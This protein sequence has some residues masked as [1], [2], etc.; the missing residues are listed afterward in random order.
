MDID[1]GNRSKK[2]ANTIVRRRAI[3]HC[4]IVEIIQ[5]MRKLIYIFISI[6]LVSGFGLEIGGT[7]WA[8]NDS[9]FV[10]KKGDNYL[11]H[12]KD[13][14][15]YVLQTASTFNPATC[16]WYSGP[17]Y[18]PTGYAHNY[19]FEDDE[20]NL[21][22]LAAP[23]QPE[24]T[25][26][27]SSSLPSV[28]MLRNTDQ[29]YYF[30]NW[31]PET[32]LSGVPEGGGIAKGHR[33]YVT[34][35][36][37]PSQGATSASWSSNQCWEVYWIEN[38]GNNWKMS[39][40]S[41][42]N[43]TANAARYRKVTVT[44][45]E[46]EIKA[47]GLTALSIPSAMNYGTNSTLSA[48]VGSPYSYI[49]AYTNYVFLENGSESVHN[50]WGNS[51]HLTAVP[52]QVNNVNIVSRSYEWTI[53]GE[54]ASY[55]S[56]NSGD[57]VNTSTAESPTLYYRVENTTG[58]KEATI[59]VT[60]TYTDA[61]YEQT[62]QTLSASVLVKNPCSNPAIAADPVI[63]YTDVTVS[64]IPTA[65][66]YEVSWK[67]TSEEGGW[68]TIGVE[69]VTSYSITGL[70]FGTQYSYKVKAECDNDDAAVNN[71]TT[72]QEPGLV[73]VGAIFGG[74]RMADVGGKTEIV[75]VNCD[76][77]NAIYGGNDIAGSVSHDDGSTIT[78]GVNTGDT[79]ESYGTTPNTA[80]IKIGSVYGGGNGYYAYNGSSFVAAS[81]NYKSESIEAG[82]SV[83]AMTQ[84][85]AV[86]DVV[87]TNEG[88]SSKVLNFPSIN[89]TAIRVS[90]NYVTVD[91]IFGGAKNAFLTTNNGDGSLI[92]I[93][94][95]TIY[96]VFGGNNF[97]GGQGYGL[98]H[99]VVNGTSTC[100]TTTNNLPDAGTS[101]HQFGSDFGIA[102]LFGGGNKVYG[103]TTNIEIKGGQIDNLFGGGNAADVYAANVT[104][105]CPLA[106]YSNNFTFGNTY[107]NAIPT[108]YQNGSISIKDDYLWNGKGI[109]NVR[110]LYGGNNMESMAGVPNVTLTSGS[111]GTVYGG[112]N[113]GDML[114]S[115]AG[116]IDEDNDNSTTDVSFN[117]STKVILN[118]ANII[119][120]Y[121]YGGCRMSNVDYSTWVQIQNGHVGTVFGGCNVSGDVGSTRVNPSASSGTADYQEVQGGTYVE[122]SGGTVYKN[123]Y[124][125]GNGFY[126]CSQL[127][128]YVNVN[129][130]SYTD[131]NYVGMLVPSHNQT[132]ANVRSDANIK[133]NVYAGGNLAPVGFQD[134]VA[135][136]YPSFPTNAVGWAVV[137]IYGGNIA[138]NVF[139]GG[140]MADVYGSNDVLVAGGRMAAVYGGNDRTGQVAEYSNRVLPD[141][142]PRA[143][144]GYTSL[145]QPEVHAYVRVVGNPTI[146]EVY[147]GGNGDYDYQNGDAIV[148]QYCN[149][150]ELGPIQSNTFVDININ[151]G[152]AGGHIGTVYGG[153]DGV[154]ASG[155]ITVFINIVEPDPSV[156]HDVNINTVFGGNNKGT[157][158]LVP[159]IILL[160]GYVGTVYG[161]CNQGA[162]TATGEDF[163]KEIGGYGNI[164]SYV[165]LL[166]SYDPDRDGPAPAV[167][168][169]IK[170]KDAIYGGCRMN[171]VT[172]NSL[173]LVEGGDHSSA[174]IYGGSDI[175]G[176]VG[177]WS[178]VAVTG[179][180]TGNIYGGGNGGYKY[181]NNNAYT[182]ADVLIAEGTSEHPITAPICANSGVDILGGQVGASGVDNGKEAF[183]GGYGAETSTTGNVT[184][185]VGPATAASWSGLPVIYGNIY[186]GSALGRVNTNNE[187]LTQVNFLNGTLHGNIFGGGLGEAGD[188]NKGKTCGKVEVNISNEEQT[189]ENCKIDLRDANIYGC[190]NTN[191][192]P[193][194]DVTVHIYKTAFN[195]IDDYPSGDNYTAASGADPYYA[196]NDVF[197]GGNL[198]GYLP[199][200]ASNKALVYV[201]DCVNTIKR[202]FGGGNAAEARHAAVTIEGG[203]MDQVFGGGNGEV[204]A[205]NIGDGGIEL[206]I[207]GGKIRQLFG[208]NNTSGNIS[209]PMSINVTNSGTCTEA[210]DEF[211]GGSNA[212]PMGSNLSP[213]TLN[214]TIGCDPQH[215][216]NIHTVYG[217]SCLAPIVGDVTL[218]IEGGT[219]TD[220][221]AG[222][223]GAAGTAATITGST[224]LNLYGGTVSENAFGG[225][226]VNGNITGKITVNVLDY[227]T[228][229]LNVHNVYGA[230]NATNY[231]PTPTDPPISSPEVNVIHVSQDAGISGNVYGGGRQGAVTADPV[232]NIGYYALTMSGLIPSNYPATSSLT[233][234]PRAFVT[235]NVFGGGEEAGVTGNP[236]INM[237]SGTVLGGLYGG[238]NINGIVTGNTT[239]LFTGGTMGAAAVG[240]EGQVGYVAQQN[241]NIYGGGLGVNTKVKGNVEVTINSA[242]GHIYGDVYGGSA[243][244]LVNC[245]DAGNARHDGTTTTLALSAGTIHGDLYG[246]GLG[247]LSTL[248]GEGHSNIEAD[249]WGPVTV[250][251]TGGNVK[252]IF[253]GNN[254]NGTPKNTIQVNYSGGTAETV[255]G[256]GNVASYSAPD[257]QLDYPEV[258][259][260]GGTVT[261]RVIG[262]GNEAN[263]TGNPHVNISGGTIGTA[264]ASRGIYGGCNTSGT[265][266]GNVF[267]T[268]T[269]GTVGASGVTNGAN[270]H[271]G[272]YGNGTSVTGNVTVTFGDIDDSQREYPRLYG[273][274]YGGSALGNVNTNNENNTTVNVYNGTIVG[275]VFGGGLGNSSYA[276]LVNGVVNV[277]IGK[278]IQDGDVQPTFVG[279]ATLSKCDV[280]GCNNENGT[281]KDNVFVN[282]YCTNRTAEE[283][284][285]AMTDEYAIQNVFGGGKRAHYNPD[286]DQKTR[287]YVYGCDNTA[288]FLYAGGDAADAKGVQIVVEG[289]RFYEAYAGG[290][291]LSKP[292]NIGS[293]GTAFNFH[294]GT[295]GYTYEGSNK[296]GVNT[297]GVKGIPPVMKWNN[298]Q[299]SSNCGT[300]LIQN[301]YFGANKAEI[302][303]EVLENTIECN[304]NVSYRKVYAG[305]RYAII[306]G[307]VKLTVR[308]GTIQTLYGGSQGYSGFSA[309]IR[310]Y[311]TQEEINADVTIPPK[312]SNEL[313]D[314]MQTHRDLEGKGGNV[315]LVVTGGTIGKIVGGCDERGNVEGKISVIVADEGNVTCPLQVGDVYG[316]SSHAYYEPDN[317]KKDNSPQ[318]NL[319]KC[320]LGLQYDFNGNIDPDNPSYDAGE[321]FDGNVFGG[322]E[323]SNIVSN[324]KVIIG[325]GPNAVVTV[326]GDVYGGGNLGNV[327]GS[328]Q[329]VVVPSPSHTLNIGSPEHGTISIPHISTSSAQIGEGVEI[330]VTA[331]P[332]NGYAFVGWTITETNPNQDV[333]KHA[334]MNYTNRATTT[335]TMGTS[336]VSIN[337]TFVQAHTI[338]IINPNHGSI[339]VTDNHGQDVNNDDLI[340]EG[341]VLTIEAIPDSALSSGG[342]VFSSWNATG[343]TPANV[344]STT[345]TMPSSN[346]TL[347]ATFT[348]APSHLLTITG[349]NGTYIVNGKN[350]NGN[351]SVAEG[352]QVTIKVTPA[353]GYAFSSWSSVSGVTI[354]NT[355]SPVIT[356]TMGNSDVNLTASYST[357]PELNIVAAVENTGSFKVNGEIYSSVISI[358]PNASTSV[359]A[360]PA[361]GFAF[362]SWSVVGTGADVSS[363]TSATT[364][365][366]MGTVD[367]TLTANFVALHGLVITQG[368]NGTFT[369]TDRES[370]SLT[371]T[372]FVGEGATLNLVATPAY[373]YQFKEWKVT[374]A[375]SRVADA[376]DATT[377]FTMGSVDATLTAIYE[378][379]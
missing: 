51:D 210:I 46:K 234:Y 369:V 253:G 353:L 266:T 125:G 117:Y 154:T 360:I 181:L 290:N 298:N 144:D 161:G 38:E 63:T 348:F 229:P 261:N 158:D 47:G 364:T 157:L 112:G 248:E 314:Y 374:G 84:E 69:N 101:G 259:V 206:S 191:G 145:L 376:T 147:G 327:D 294:G 231:E 25:L 313:R 278:M 288:E 59:T 280:Y 209:G 130:I 316:A 173:V 62:T 57:D 86:G 8:Q 33:Y 132:Y 116:S 271:G 135:P 23:L 264:G 140:N 105:N 139:G 340:G 378:K 65:D 27:L 91:S 54:G 94:G 361:I 152:D 307:D 354:N 220:V 186:G 309:D 7:A 320:T 297:G 142:Y 198:A 346:V 19:Y 183:G 331:I 317:S 10:I 151:G 267:V 203:R 134:Q 111:V 263:V 82:A 176:N 349:T 24:G 329:V 342:Y 18:N 42:Y 189:A 319:L 120:D 188:A 146:G 128:H 315:T 330:P 22:F 178:R 268:L 269:G 165:H 150:N 217:G 29:I 58:H 240:T 11:A 115:N 155:F 238:C 221:Y 148:P 275:Q 17:T 45:H 118:S 187:N 133:G 44:E 68:N 79:Y 283:L 359:Q 12:V 284:V 89:K 373:G 305:S 339:K 249:V 265:V 257:G 194:D 196:I 149:E 262:G 233:N 160:H 136:D 328:P 204:S 321:E 318:V 230:S 55:L 247:D 201:H 169:T 50:F 32:Y 138:G 351:V 211:Y 123:L 213:V 78:L 129:N 137:H 98:H 379:E 110:N 13:G 74:G 126:H 356:F 304:D 246:G 227:E 35:G 159:N 122:A 103:S 192:S 15:D 358:P 26:S 87:W 41:S 88:S 195:Y 172:N 296:Q 255:V 6:I 285:V 107:T 277:N 64:W 108:T 9:P 39:S 300:A 375:G 14:G 355:S 179:G 114:A 272:G 258:N 341:T 338:T 43:I 61:N 302:Y 323:E 232:V 48:T 282:V 276:A 70:D 28:S 119:V 345:I 207:S 291:G 295:F 2:L 85:H 367:A 212:A 214:T 241:A 252:R 16:L 293:G 289:G 184:V 239:V 306:Y 182:T 162:M 244:G 223:K 226:N 93:D 336:D 121:L 92:T 170:V 40:P 365:F 281:P 299:D 371:G 251:V 60:V 3:R 370:Q 113:A 347:K 30:Y 177:G 109:Y 80:D 36:D 334:S 1:T 167:T 237:R 335:F 141:S 372:T 337:A 310:K 180:T 260:S 73:V 325:D 97:G 363:E 21:R 124:A 205:A 143:T 95:G 312:Y 215:S 236:T 166:N 250:N 324:P 72:M 202:V 225:N 77:I 83:K 218:T 303:V 224:T 106:A 52:T 352:D 243:K 75:V 163:V 37:C 326:K 222:S 219:F 279:K 104:V 343:V 175:S 193:Q 49:P 5:V 350:Y 377:T 228:C 286:G 76:T 67:K 168:P 185:N 174:S 273:A 344:S 368:E 292:A 100:L 301:H 242:T 332:A 308:G 156:D 31:D 34:E 362:D 208:G 357:A 322:G 245:N 99:I 90:N 333:T 20:H 216:V 274:L 287:L 200:S 96:A 366:T 127:F 153:G 164:G 4:L 131:E 197:G 81:S 53:S 256:G 56:F 171:G 71:F 199:A 190:N 311:P 66:S 102:Y 235:G 254:L 270:I